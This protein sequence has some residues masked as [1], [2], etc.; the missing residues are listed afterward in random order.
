MCVELSVSGCEFVCRWG[1]QLPDVW[2]MGPRRIVTRR[3]RRLNL[4]ESPTGCMKVQ[5]FVMCST[6]SHAGR[7]VMVHGTC[8]VV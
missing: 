3:L 6:V 8:R 1:F 2:R 4:A 7:E 5:K